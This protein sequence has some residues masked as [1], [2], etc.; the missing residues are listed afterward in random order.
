M[1]LRGDP[2]RYGLAALLTL[3]GT[4][5]VY[6]VGLMLA[7][8]RERAEVERRVGWLA[9]S[10]ALH[11][12]GDVDGLAALRAEIAAHPGC[13]AAADELPRTADAPLSGFTRAV[14]RDL[15]GLSARLGERWEALNVVTLAALGFAGL[16]L[17]LFALSR[18][19]QRALVAAQARLAD[20]NAA[21]QQANAAERA[22]GELKARFL[23][24]V[25]HE[26]RT[27]IQGVL[28]MAGLLVEAGAEPAER[29]RHLATLRA[30]IDDLLRMVDELLDFSRIDSGR[31][32]IRLETF[33]PRGLFEQVVALV[34]EAARRKGVALRCDLGE[35]LPDRVVG[36]AL[37]L[38]QVTL[39]LLAN[40]VKFTDEGSVVLRVRATR[41]AS[42]V[43]LHVEVRDTGPGMSREAQ[44]RLFEPFVRPSDPGSVRRAGTGLGLVISRGIV[45][46]LGGRLTVDS[47]PGVGSTFA[48]ELAFPIA[49]AA[50][51][52]PLA[53]AP[54]PPPRADPD[55][56][57]RVLVAEDDE[58]NR[59]LLHTLLTRAGYAVDTVADG[60]AAVAA[61]RARTY[62]LVLL[63][64]ELPGLTGP[65]VA[66]EL[67]QG[68]EQAALIAFTGHVET[69]VH[70]RCKAAGIDL[71]LT[72]P[73]APAQ[74]RDAVAQALRERAGPVDLQV[75]RAFHTSDDP[76][77]VP[78]VIDVFLQEVARDADTLRAPDLDPQAA[79]R[80]AHRLK[81]SADSLGARR[82]ARRCQALLDAA[83]AGLPLADVAAALI[84]EVAPV[85]QALRAEQARLRGAS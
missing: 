44:A 16:S 61:A 26:L 39:N 68:G 60:P 30:S 10:E 21:L 71:V 33:A 65:A 85:E 46:L 22:A 50:P 64:V 25:S 82:L 24:Y 66:R 6:S 48:F 35:G 81:G 69:A 13:E 34:A 1:T 32:S 29:D 78:R 76:G 15:A 37:R 27:P 36:D 7:V 8:S 12:R 84:A 51:S 72:K 41:Q 5:V 40:A 45:E 54:A 42:A 18:S 77:F 57:V 43:R 49:A 62:A 2:W 75:V 52:A 19:R 59:L 53:A 23:A 73:I 14:R 28:G 79:A 31:L 9:S 3:V 47:S 70:A 4:F 56:P 55:E 20:A 38:R 80:L 58:T 67:R 83:R 74:L 63:D 17:A 11:A